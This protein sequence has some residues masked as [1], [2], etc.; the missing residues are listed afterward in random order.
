LEK[1]L[2]EELAEF[3]RRNIPS[4]YVLEVLL[5]IAK[6]PERRWT[7]NSVDTEL[8]SNHFLVTNAL[9]HLTNKKLI[10]F[11]GDCYF[12]RPT[13]GSEN[14]NI[15]LVIKLATTHFNKLVTAVYSDKI[16]K[17]QSLADAFKIKKDE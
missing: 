3:I 6:N 12:Y 1:F 5:L 7:V 4:I 16:H 2:T 8:R 15:K 14:E 13:S 9:N 11:D 10:E 17:I